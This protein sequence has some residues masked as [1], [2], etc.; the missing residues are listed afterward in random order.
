MTEDELELKKCPY[1]RYLIPSGRI[2]CAY[3][4][5]VSPTLWE[6]RVT[7]NWELDKSLDGKGLDRLAASIANKVH[8]RDHRTYNMYEALH[9]AAEKVDKIFLSKIAIETQLK[10]VDIL[11]DRFISLQSIGIKYDYR[12]TY[13]VAPR[14]GCKLFVFE[15]SDLYRFIGHD[16]DTIT[17]FEITKALHDKVILAIRSEE[18]RKFQHQKERREKENEARE[19]RRLIKKVRLEAEYEQALSKYNMLPWWKRWITRPPKIST[20]ETE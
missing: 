17:I 14:E 7:D 3:C 12:Q 5:T 1:C 10:D 13:D 2:L 9:N 8:H 20:V 15:I 19:N 11:F 18:E 6:K 4:G 16:G